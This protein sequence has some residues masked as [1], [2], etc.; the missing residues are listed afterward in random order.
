MSKQIIAV[1]VVGTGGMGMRHAHN[2]TNHVVGAQVVAVM[3]IDRQKAKTL[4]DMCGAGKI[5]TDAK[6]LINDPS[7]DAV[8]IASPD[9]THADLI[10]TCLKAKKPVL[11]EKPL[12]MSAAETKKIVDAEIEGG[13]RLIQVGFMREYDPP[14]RAVK[15]LVDKGEVGKTVLIR[16]V[17]TTLNLNQI[18]PLDNVVVRSAVHDIHSLRWLSGSEIETVFVQ[19]VPVVPEEPK[20][21][22][23]LLAQ[24][25]FQNGSLGVIELNAATQHGYEVNVEVIGEEG[26]IASNTLHGPVIHRSGTSQKKIEPGWLERFDT[27]Y[28]KEVQAWI[29]S[30]KQETPTGP[31]AW[32]GY[33]ALVV[34]DTFLKSAESGTPQKVP[35]IEKP[36]LYA[37]D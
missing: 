10:M 5:Y 21:C 28:I 13:R 31:S 3:D 9:P 7:V 35:V 8:V 14:H 17:H 19:W 24:V 32:D 37:N 34:T 2:L 6:D 4:A 22:R 15:E 26:N 12:G 30:L 29:D 23:Y 25:S 16:D 18:R 36:A 33:A 11:T 1:G 20:S 27:A